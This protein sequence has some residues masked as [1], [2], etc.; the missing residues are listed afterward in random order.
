VPSNINTGRP[1]APSAASPVLLPGGTISTAYNA[2]LS[3]L[4][5]LNVY[6]PTL[7]VTRAQRLNTD[8]NTYPYVPPGTFANYL[9][10]ETDTGAVYISEFVISSGTVNTVGTAVT[11]AS[12]SLFY[13]SW[14]GNQ[15]TIGGTVYTVTAV[16]SATSLT[17][18]ASAGTHSGLVY[19][20][21]GV[22]TWVWVTGTMDGASL[23]VL[24]TGLGAS[25][26]GFRFNDLTYDHSYRW[27]G[28]A[29]TFAP[30]DDHMAGQMCPS[31]GGGAPLGGVWS[32]CTGGAVTVSKGDG[33]TTSIA[34]PNLTGDVMI[35]GA[36]A[37]S[38]QQVAVRAT[39]DPTAVTDD[40][41]THTHSVHVN[42]TNAYGS[43]SFGACPDQ[44]VTSGPGSAHHH[45][46]SN[47]NA[48][49]NPPSE[50]NGGLGIRIGLVWWIRQ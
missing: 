28:T 11:W 37:Q 35:K 12:G 24:P 26:I 50:A 19:A 43:G 15:I 34:T 16:A 47:T 4:G 10:Y 46:L 9:C 49:L 1:P 3:P 13:T 44:T 36:A 39:W 14:K 42:G 17:I 38:G 33:T 23:A 40:E 5:I 20:Q 21:S 25:D 48:K 18:S 27:T 30:E 29:W 7:E 2:F 6:G 32:A 8:P 31:A 45:G 41:A 22:P